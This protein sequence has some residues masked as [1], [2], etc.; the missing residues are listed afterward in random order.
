[1]SADVERRAATHTP[2]DVLGSCKRGIYAAISAITRVPVLQDERGTYLISVDMHSALFSGCAAG[3]V[4][5][6]RT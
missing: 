6:V 4:A 5:R 3:P 1:M 2:P